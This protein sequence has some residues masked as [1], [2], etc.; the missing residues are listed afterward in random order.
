MDYGRSGT[1]RSRSVAISF[2]R[3]ECLVSQCMSY[4][5][6]TFLYIATGE[7]ITNEFNVSKYKWAKFMFFLLAI[8]FVSSLYFIEELTGGG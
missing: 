2:S 8:G 3:F 5:I 1:F 4:F 6:G 7:I